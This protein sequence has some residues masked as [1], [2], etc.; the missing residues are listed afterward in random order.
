[1]M[2]RS[3]GLAKMSGNRSCQFG[4]KTRLR[5]VW[6]LASY[7]L[8]TSCDADDHYDFVNFVHQL[9][10]LGTK[11]PRPLSF[12]LHVNIFKIATGGD[13]LHLVSRFFPPSSSAA[14][15]SV[16]FAYHDQPT[17]DASA[18]QICLIIPPRPLSDQWLLIRNLSGINQS[19]PS[20]DHHRLSER[21][22]HS[23]ANL[24]FSR[25]KRRKKEAGILCVP[26]TGAASGDRRRL[27]FS[28]SF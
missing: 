3:S 13:Q 9:R 24:S 12:Y 27:G 5:R 6:S 14:R 23:D 25:K 28:G 11:I 20:S 18:D 1:M 7:I 8:K 15:T 21:R 19:P 26:S 16:L 10:N 22:K 4:Q 2:M 17:T